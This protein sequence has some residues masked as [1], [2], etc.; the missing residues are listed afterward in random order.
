MLIFQQNTLLAIVEQLLEAPKNIQRNNN[1]VVSRGWKQMLHSNFSLSCAAS[2]WAFQGLGGHR[3]EAWSPK[4]LQDSGVDAS[5]W[6][7]PPM[8]TFTSHSKSFSLPIASEW[9]TGVGICQLQGQLLLRQQWP[10]MPVNS[11]SQQ[12]VWITGWFK[13][14]LTDPVL[15]RC[16]TYIYWC[17]LMPAATPTPAGHGAGFRCWGGNHPC[18]AVPPNLG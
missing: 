11:L 5:S 13:W 4:G 15:S 12:G 2:K 16:S 3:P 9:G 18:L 10:A 17:L 14:L 8:L 6:T 1:S 7:H